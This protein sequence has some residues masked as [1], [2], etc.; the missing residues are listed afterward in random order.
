MSRPLLRCCGASEQLA[1]RPRRAC[2]TSS[3]CGTGS[4]RSPCG[5]SGTGGTSCPLALR[6]VLVRG[7]CVARGLLDQLRLDLVL[8]HGPGPSVEGALAADGHTAASRPAPS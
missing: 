8:V 5:T 4:T 3:T 6:A 7:V 1:R 2:R